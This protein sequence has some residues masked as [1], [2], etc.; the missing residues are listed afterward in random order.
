MTLDILSDTAVT[1]PGSRIGRYSFSP[2]ALRDPGLM[3]K[4]LRDGRNCK[5]SS[6]SIANV[7]Q[8][9][10]SSL[11]DRSSWLGPLSSTQTPSPWVARGPSRPQSN[12]SAGSTCNKEMVSAGGTCRESW[13]DPRFP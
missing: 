3:L 4:S 5:A 6:H 12:R 9:C 13:E 1:P 8:R 11:A 2:D 7:R 10:Q